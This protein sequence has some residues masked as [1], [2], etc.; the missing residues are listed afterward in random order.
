MNAPKTS[1][2]QDD[3]L[4]AQCGCRR[5]LRERKEGTQIGDCFLPAE[6]T[7]MV[8]CETCGNKRCPHANDHANACTNSNAPG[9]V[10]SA[11]Q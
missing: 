10:G 6:M 3:T 5:C 9:Q 2:S 11:Y 4:A 7:Q 1:A 8:V